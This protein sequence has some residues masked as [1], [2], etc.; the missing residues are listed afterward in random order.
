MLMD[1]KRPEDYKK[2]YQKLSQKSAE[3][4][5]M[6]PWMLKNM[7]R[8]WPDEGCSLTLSNWGKGAICDCFP[9]PGLSSLLGGARE[10][11]RE[12]LEACL[13]PK[14]DQHN[15]RISSHGVATSP[16]KNCVW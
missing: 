6:P 1:P 11:G 15:Y 2:Q 4:G 3:R 13:E 14:A 7:S 5:A 16:C 9:S 8:G 12:G 10:D